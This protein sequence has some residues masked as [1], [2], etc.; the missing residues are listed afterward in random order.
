MPPILYDGLRLFLGAL[1][2]TPRGVDRVDLSYARFLLENWDNECLGVLPTPWGIRLYNRQRALRMLAT[3]EA[4]WRE[5]QDVDIDPA[6][7]HVREW[8]TSTAATPQA[9]RAPRQTGP[10]RRTVRLL[11]DNG[12]HWGHSAIHEAPDKA[13]YLNVGQLGWA[14]PVTT[15]WLRHRP[16][17]KSIFMLHDVI[18]LHHPGLVSDGARLSQNWMLRSVLSRADG[19][20]TTTESASET[21]TATLARFGRPNVPVRALPLPVAAVFLQPEQPDKALQTNPY[22]VVCG[23]IEPRKNH[24]LLVRV[25]RCLLDRI[26]PGAPRLLIVGTPA[27][28]GSQIIRQIQQIAELRNH[29]TIVSGVASPSLRA[30]MR[31]ARAVLMPSL[32][33]GFG[34]PLIEALSVGT[35]VLASD[36]AAHRET[37]EGLVAYLDPENDAAWFD[38]IVSLLRNTAEITAWR[39]RISKYN[40]LTNQDYFRSVGEFLSRFE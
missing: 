39:Q 5:A 28:R 7:A 19:L 9:T 40:P 4:S 36:L 10:L 22:F 17:I 37:G 8:L 23:A 38:A 20:I 14:A 25:W 31:N 18:P 26:G 16:D 35:P 29:V 11:R 6:F 13:V 30:L 15:R 12:L 27:H 3:V 34:L 2:R 32:A 21:V 24:A 1:Y 33:E